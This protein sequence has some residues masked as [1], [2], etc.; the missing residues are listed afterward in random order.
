MFTWQS[1]EG[2]LRVQSSST[3]TILLS[4]FQ[5]QLLLCSQTLKWEIPGQSMCKLLA[6]WSIHSE[7]SCPPAL[8]CSGVC[9]LLLW[10]IRV[11][12]YTPWISLQ[13]SLLSVDHYVPRCLQ[14]GHTCFTNNG[15]KVSDQSH[16]QFRYEKENPKISPFKWSENSRREDHVLS[17]LRSLMRV[18]FLSLKL[19][20]Q[21][22]K[23]LLG[24]L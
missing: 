19:Q 9:H 15:P 20:K 21:K 22:K 23:L 4:W 10:R 3:S 16:W 1:Q 11:I 2:V 17:L 13:L 24:L 7:I 12:H 8:P 14:L 6:F 18:N 5:Y